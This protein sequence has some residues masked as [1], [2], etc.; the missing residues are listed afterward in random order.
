M[1]HI[2]LF[3]IDKTLIARSTAHLRAFFLSLET[4]YGVTAEPNVIKHHGLTDRQIIREVLRAKGVDDTTIDGG[5]A[6]CIRVMVDKFRELNPSDDLE[7]LPGVAVLLPEL[8]KRNALLGLVTGNIEEIAWEKLAQAGIAGYFTFG[9]FGSDN[10][11]R[12]IMA[13]IALQRCNAVYN[14]T[15]GN[16]VALFGDTPYDMA[17]ARA[18]GALAFGVATGHPSKGQ[19]SAAGAD[20]VFDNL[21]DTEKVLG[22]VFSESLAET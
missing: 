8:A 16:P 12:S 3:D 7:L 19:L 14:L 17:A 9:G 4:V 21:A 13:A 22:A 11:D 10:E 18:I 5:L 15:G 20:I 2:V 6:G 1:K